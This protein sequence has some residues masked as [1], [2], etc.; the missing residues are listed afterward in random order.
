M[1]ENCPRKNARLRQ[2]QSGRGPPS[3]GR[4][5]N[6]TGMLSKLAEIDLHRP[7]ASSPTPG[8]D[9][10]WRLLVLDE[11][12]QASKHGAK[13]T[14]RSRS[15]GARAHCVTGTPT[16]TG[17][18]SVATVTS[19]SGLRGYPEFGLRQLSP[20]VHKP[21]APARS[22]PRN[23]ARLRR[24]R[25]MMIADKTRGDILTLSVRRQR[26]TNKRSGIDDR[27]KLRME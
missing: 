21:T 11:A 19:Q 7:T 10:R 17:R 1:L 12:A 9:A 3:A 14:N 8:G 5:K 16:R 13:K 18:R 4:P 26:F 25:D 23:S 15:E 22:V 2:A 27:S 6:G 24:T 20:Q